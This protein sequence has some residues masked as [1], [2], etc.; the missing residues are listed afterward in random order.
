MSTLSQKVQKQAWLKRHVSPKHKNVG[1]KNNVTSEGDHRYQLTSDVLAR[2]INEAKQRLTENRAF[3]K[4][5]REELRDYNFTL[6][7][8]ETE[9]LLNLQ[10][11]FK[12]LA[13]KRDGEKFYSMF[14]S[15]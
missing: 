7:S 15:M 5:V 12:C 6:I 3:P 2:L 13:K 9:E 1:E 14:Y 10:N 4:N 11:V 8:E